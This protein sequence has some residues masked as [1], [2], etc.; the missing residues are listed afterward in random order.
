MGHRD[1]GVR[2]TRA[3]RRKTSLAMVIAALAGLLL[4]ACAGGRP[5]DPDPGTIPAP[6][7]TVDREGPTPTQPTEM[8]TTPT[9]PAP[10]GD[11]SSDRPGDEGSS[12]VATPESTATAA[13]EFGGACSGFPEPNP[14]TRARLLEVDDRCLKIYQRLCKG[15]IPAIFEPSFLGADAAGYPDFEPV[16]GLSINGEHRAYPILFL[17]AH[18]VVNDT[19]GG[20]PVAVTW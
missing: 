19:V 3:N 1:V 7:A 5:E 12:E 8:A 15:C 20:K 17:S 11:A 16:L 10:I 13:A 4:T 14:L 6:A 2:E 9:P 18:E